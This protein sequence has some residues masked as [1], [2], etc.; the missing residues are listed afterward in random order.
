MRDAE[1]SGLLRTAGTS[2]PAAAPVPEASLRTTLPPAIVREHSAW[3]SSAQ[4]SSSGTAS[5]RAAA[6]NS[7]AVG[8][9]GSAGASRLRRT[10]R[11]FASGLLARIP[12][13]VGIAW[14]VLLAL[15]FAVVLVGCVGTTFW[16]LPSSEVA[17]HTL[18]YRALAYAALA[19]LY[20]FSDRR[21]L[22]RL[23]RLKRRSLGRDGA[24]VLSLE[25]AGLLVFAFLTF[26]G[27]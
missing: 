4:A 17:S 20:F 23:L 25:A 15:V 16:P 13:G 12:R 26:S 2:V 3:P 7:K 22:R 1:G 21:P 11:S 14:D 18:A 6:A 8:R 5:A 9:R 19:F 24:I 10:V 27:W